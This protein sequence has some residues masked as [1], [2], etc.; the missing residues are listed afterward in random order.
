MGRLAKR[1]HFD[2][3]RPVA[4]IPCESGHVRFVLLKHTR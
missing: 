4:Q 2:A 3:S 1:L